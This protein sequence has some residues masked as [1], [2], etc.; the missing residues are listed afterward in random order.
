[1]IIRMATDK[2]L[3]LL[4]DMNCQLIKDEGHSNPMSISELQ[5][6]MK[7]WLQGGY[8]AALIEVDSE[9]VGY[10]LWRNDKRHLYIRQFF[11]QPECRH[12]HVGTI[13]IQSLKQNHWHNRLIRLEVLVNNQRGHSFWQSA[14]FEDYSLTMWCKNA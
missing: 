5:D 4:A 2:D 11:V 10:A 1:M 14:G 3:S 6:R 12:K 8:S 13:A 7:S 9:I